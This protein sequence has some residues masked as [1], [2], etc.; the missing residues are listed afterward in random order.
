MI[1]MYAWTV[2]DRLHVAAATVDQDGQGREVVRGVGSAS[3]PLSR[4]V[5]GQRLDITE[6]AARTL[7]EMCGGV[8]GERL[9][10]RHEDVHTEL[11]TGSLQAELGS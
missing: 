11:W 4:A 6:L 2:V 1:R 3:V 10:L 5:R 9:E 7:I 8:S